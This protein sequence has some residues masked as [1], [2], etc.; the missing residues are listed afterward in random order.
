MSQKEKML[1]TKRIF[2]TAEEFDIW[3]WILRSLA[4]VLEKRPESGKSSEYPHKTYVHR[5][6]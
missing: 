1:F 2:K 5:D 6:P 3:T 4:K